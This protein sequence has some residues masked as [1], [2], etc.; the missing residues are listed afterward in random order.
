MKRYDFNHDWE[1]RTLGRGAEAVQ[2]TLPH[3]AMRT[4]SRVSTS[5]GE[6]HIGWYEGNDYEYRKRFFLPAELKGKKLIQM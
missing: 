3:D 4:E 2:V 6:R 1:C 5:L